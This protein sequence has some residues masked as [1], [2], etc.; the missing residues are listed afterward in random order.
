MSALS[1]KAETFDY[2]S[3]SAVP[4]TYDG[5]CPVTIK[6]ESLVRFDI[7]YNRQEKYSYRWEGGDEALTEFVTTFSK[8]RNNRVEGTAEISAP[9]GKTMTI[10]IRLHTVWSLTFGKTD[11]NHGKS[12]N[13]HYSSPFNVTVTCR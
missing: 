4:S 5:P 9:T 13:D 3:A 10:P 12:V 2:L 7:D 8:G 1:A 11:S 6:L